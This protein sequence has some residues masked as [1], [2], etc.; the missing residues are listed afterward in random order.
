MAN[1]FYV[2][3]GGTKSTGAEYTSKQ[4]GSF[5]SLT[6]ANYYDSIYDAFVNSDTAPT[7][8][9]FVLVSDA[10]AKTL[11][12]AGYT[13]TS[14]SFTSSLLVISVS[15]TAVDDYSP[16]A[17][18]EGT[19]S[20]GDISIEY[21][22]SILGVSV[23]MG[24][25]VFVVQVV[26]S[27]L[28]L[29]DLTINV[30]NDSFDTAFQA[31]NDGSHI[32]LTNVDID[33]SSAL[34]RTINMGGAAKFEWNGG[35]MT[36]TEPDNFFN[37]AG[38]NGGATI[39]LTGVDMSLYSNTILPALVAGT[40]DNVLMRM[41]N[42]LLNDN[43]TLHG[44]LGQAHQRFEMFNCDGATNKDYH[45][46]YIADGA[47]TAKNNDTVYVTATEA[48]YGGSDKSS[49]QVDTTTNCDRVMPFVFELPAQYVDLSSASSDVIT[50]EMVTAETLK[51]QDVAAFLCYPDGTTATQPNWVSSGP[52]VGSGN[53]GIDPLD[54]TTA[55]PTGALAEG[56]WTDEPVN[57]IFYKM[58]LDTSGDAGQ[59]TAVSVRIEV[60]K[61]SIGPIYIHPLF[62]LS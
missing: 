28:V 15:D 50:I 18:E 35:V 40:A 47:G 42:C 27:L 14:G 53:Y 33:Y 17:S 57:P 58:T 55:M 56:D 31:I 44:T 37:N 7:G 19:D 48:W 10:H 52:S 20:Q 11:V 25:H 36:G 8:G 32:K 3:S 62:T 23:K 49:I 54:S 46:F 43:V 61:A 41:Q 38:Y 45:G 21:Y 34:S 6:A 4:T 22:V 9:D 51:K 26:G 2:K 30:D 1:Y 29:T 13:M 39:F 5:A 24:D 60:Y 16:G 12:G 59:A